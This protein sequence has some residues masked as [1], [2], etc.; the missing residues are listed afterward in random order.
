MAW[1]VRTLDRRVDKEIKALPVQ[2]RASFF[3]VVDLLIEHG[4]ENVGM[5]YVATWTLVCGKYGQREKKV[6][7]AV[8]M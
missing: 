6:S 2:V 4:P 3:R 7:G 8:S 5:P 1:R